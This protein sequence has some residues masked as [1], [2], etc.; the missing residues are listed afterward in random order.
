MLLQ[1]TLRLARDPGL[2]KGFSAM[3]SVGEE[4][5]VVFLRI[6]SRFT[7][8]DFLMFSSFGFFV[9]HVDVLEYAGTP[10]W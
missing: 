6:A 3:G 7:S 5:A 2:S 1:V 9:R 8:T 10:G 4:Q